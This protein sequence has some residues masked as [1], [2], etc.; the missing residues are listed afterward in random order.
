M[1]RT[2]LIIS[3][4][5][6]DVLSGMVDSGS[7]AINIRIKPTA[8]HMSTGDHS[9]EMPGSSLQA[10]ISIADIII[11]EHND[12]CSIKEVES[13]TAML[14]LWGNVIAGILGAIMTS[15]WG[16]VSDRYG[17]VK[18]LGAA[19]ATML[20]SQGIEVLMAVLPDFFTLK[21]IYVSYIFEGLR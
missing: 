15:V 10:N 5:C 21:W 12:Q 6:R 19:T 2:N 4:T 9:G 7:N 3:L 14:S 18:A 17:R 16:R 20:L 11:G 13:A 1:P 8:R